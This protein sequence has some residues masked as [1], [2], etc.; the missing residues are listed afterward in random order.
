MQSRQTEC[1][2]QYDPWEALHSDLEVPAQYCS[3]PRPSSS[4][5]CSCQPSCTPGGASP[6]SQPCVC[7][8]QDFCG[9]GQYCWADGTCSEYREPC[10]LNANGDPTAEC[11]CKRGSDETVCETGSY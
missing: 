8:E 1:Q 5:T 11:F 2:V 7:E 6:Q 3:D 10:A 4:Q 9:E